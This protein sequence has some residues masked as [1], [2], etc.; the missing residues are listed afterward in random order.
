[1]FIQNV[2]SYDVIATQ[3]PEK[4]VEKFK[5]SGAR[6]LFSAEEVCWPDASLTSLYPE[7]SD[8]EK[9][10][11]NSG[12][13]IGYASDLYEILTEKAI[14]DDEDDQLYYTLIFLNLLKRVRFFC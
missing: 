4:V 14:N 10:F 1:M 11:L 8:K 13:I 9:R 5:N 6:I 2:I 7:V 12:G 3:E